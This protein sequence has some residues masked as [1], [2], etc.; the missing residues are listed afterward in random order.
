MKTSLVI[1]VKAVA[2]VLLAAFPSLVIMIVDNKV[3]TR[4][5]LCLELYDIVK[6]G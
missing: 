1:S 3:N 4:T 6:L 5:L 2:V